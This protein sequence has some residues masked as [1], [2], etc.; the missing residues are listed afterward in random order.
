MKRLFVSLPLMML[1]TW[2]PGLGQ[3]D[4]QEKRILSFPTELF[5]LKVGDRWTYQTADAKEKVAV[6][7]ERM[8]PIKRRVTTANGAERSEM[9]ESYLV[10]V[11]N[12]EKVL[13]EQYMVTDDG[14]YRYAAGGKE[15]TPPVKILKLPAASGDTWSV[16]SVSETVALKGDF[17]VE[18]TTVSLPGRGEVSAYLSKTRDFT[19]GDQKM[20]ASYW[21]V[22][23]IGIVKQHVK[24]GKYDFRITLEEF[25][26]AGAAAS[27]PPGGAANLPGVPKLPPALDLK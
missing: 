24:V 15:I 19:V 11:A 16:N 10:R 12:G 23:G 14:V 22:P 9:I 4:K 13:Q 6:A 20:D 26:Q 25:R 21:F 2:S 18:Q 27:V 7:V 1:V 3:Q 8:E 5:P 17:V